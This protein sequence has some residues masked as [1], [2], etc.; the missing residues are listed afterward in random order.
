VP[1]PPVHTHKRSLYRVKGSSGTDGQGLKTGPKGKQFH[2]H[3]RVFATRLAN[4]S[5]QFPDRD[6]CDLIE[7]LW[8]LKQV[9]NFLTLGKHSRAA[10]SERLELHVS[11]FMSRNNIL[12]TV[13][14]SCSEHAYNNNVLIEFLKVCYSAVQPSFVLGHNS[15]M[16]M[17]VRAPP[18][19]YYY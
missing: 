19:Y 1:F 10:R 2:A 9:S 7:A 16:P 8:S 3:E 17:G 12:L 4:K 14:F 5:L 6:I 15:L 11:A 18:H 13:F